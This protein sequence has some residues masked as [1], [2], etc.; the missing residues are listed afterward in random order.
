MHYSYSRSNHSYEGV[1]EKVVYH[2]RPDTTCRLFLAELFAGK[3]RRMG[4]VKPI[5]KVISPV[6][7]HTMDS[8]SGGW[9]R[10]SRDNE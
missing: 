7:C 10:A 8:M 2:M 9:K 5:F 6:L 3:A 4:S 1:H